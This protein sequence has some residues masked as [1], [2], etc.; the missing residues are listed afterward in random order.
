LTSIFSVREMTKVGFALA[1]ALV[2]LGYWVANAWPDQ[3]CCSNC[4]IVH[5]QVERCDGHVPGCYN[6]T[7]YT[8][9]LNGLMQAINPSQRNYN[10]C[11]YVCDEPHRFGVEK[12]CTPSARMGLEGVVLIVVGALVTLY[13]LP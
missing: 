3:V 10:Q 1:C 7:T 6:V 9:K 13:I 8:V 12:C 2:V 4:T 5:R 11:W